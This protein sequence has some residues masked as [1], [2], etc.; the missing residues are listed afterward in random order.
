MSIGTSQT[1]MQRLFKKKEMEQHIQELWNSNKRYNI[2]RMG[3]SEEKEWEEK[4][5]T[6]YIWSDNGSEFS[7]IDDRF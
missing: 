2:H 4:K 6:R 7:K 1:E 3:L 5:P